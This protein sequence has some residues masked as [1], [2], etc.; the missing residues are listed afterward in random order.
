MKSL[1]IG[2]GLSALAFAASASA[3]VYFSTPNEFILDRACDA[4]TSIKKHSNVSTLA[5]GQA[6]PALGTNREPNPTHAYIQ[7]GADKKW[8]ELSC[9]HYSNAPANTAAT[10][11]RPVTAPGNACL[12]F[13]DNTDNPVKLKNGLA[14][15]TPPA[16]TID[17]FGQ[18]INAVCGSVGNKVSPDEFKQ[19]MHNFP[20]VLQGIQ[21]FTQNKVF[22][23][24]PAS[25]SSEAYLNELTEA[26]FA[27]RA[28][29]H[30]F[31]GEPEA[32]GPIGGMHYVGRY[33][34]LQNTG[35]ACRMDNYRQNEVV[36]GV[37]YSMGAVMH[38]G[39]NVARSSIKGYGLT[40]SAEDILK[41]GTRAFA[42]N[43][44]DSRDKTTACLAPVQDD[45]YKF[46]V[47]FARRS[48]GIRTLYPDATPSA[49]D[50]N[51]QNSINLN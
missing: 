5:A 24:R 40:L 4:V 29:D 18:A 49:T 10:Q 22:A 35:E 9:G 28:F 1:Q 8:V 15:I 34:Q 51:C 17:A 39:N 32:N 27:V 36:P 19:L 16:P 43:P 42:E 26:W 37:L 31:C 12:P 23:N 41:A 45:G 21:A 44:T 46:T 47:V 13:F 33:V 20:K 48:A 7:M 14:D 11:P 50:P 3:Q 2:L 6:F 30:V 38:F 25:A